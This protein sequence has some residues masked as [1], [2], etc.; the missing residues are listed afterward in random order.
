MNH[1]DFTIVVT[2]IVLFLMVYWVLFPSVTCQ[3]SKA[4][5]ILTE[6]ISRAERNIALLKSMITFKRKP[7]RP[8]FKNKTGQTKKE[9]QIDDE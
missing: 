7:G 2:L 6:G 9:I 5:E 3:C 1:I 8:P 4:I